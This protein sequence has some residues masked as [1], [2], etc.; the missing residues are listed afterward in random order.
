MD[1]GEQCAVVGGVLESS[2]LGLWFI[3]LFKSS[4][5]SSSARLFIDY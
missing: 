2:L 1:P 3:V 4:V 5:C